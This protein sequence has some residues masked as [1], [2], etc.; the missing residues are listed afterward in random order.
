MII[1]K[2]KT[3]IK[4]NYYIP[5]NMLKTTTKT[6]KTLPKIKL[7]RRGEEI[8]MRAKRKNEMGGGGVL[9]ANI[10]FGITDGTLIV[11]GGINFCR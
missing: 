8:E 3:K 9:Y 5:F 4:K 2:K 11:V 6:I 1:K 10:S 7:K